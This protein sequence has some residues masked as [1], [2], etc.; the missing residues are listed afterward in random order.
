MQQLNN[1]TVNKILRGGWR[2]GRGLPGHGK[3]GLKIKDIKTL[4]K[5]YFLLFMLLSTFMRLYLISFLFAGHFM[6]ADAF[7]IVVI[8]FN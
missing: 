7:I 8:S 6:R 5:S 2:G 3:M 1:S 4:R